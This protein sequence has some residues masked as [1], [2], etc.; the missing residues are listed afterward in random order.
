MAGGGRDRPERPS[1]G[2]R[3]EKPCHVGGQAGRWSS[4]G[5]GWQGGGL[6]GRGLV[7]RGLDI[8]RNASCPAC[9]PRN[10][11]VL[12]A[13][14]VAAGPHESTHRSTP[15]RRVL[16]NHCPLR[17]QYQRVSTCTYTS[18]VLPLCYLEY[19]CPFLAPRYHPKWGSWASRLHAAL[20]DV[21]SVVGWWRPTQGATSRRV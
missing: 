16:P 1:S 20:C 13:R 11:A 5:W 4:P 12:V 17:T 8:A 21:G 19:A 15:P 9:R 6:V 2:A 10:P 18:S 7:G 14:L 3:A